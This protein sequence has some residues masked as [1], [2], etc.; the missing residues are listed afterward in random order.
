M[1]RNR[2]TKNATTGIYN[3]NEGAVKAY[4]L[5][6]LAASYKVN[7]NTRLSVG[8][9]NLFNEDYFPARAQWFMQPGFYSKGRGTAINIGVSIRY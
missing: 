3:G 4:N 5:F 9:E 7:S 1:N 8:I 6:N 2:F